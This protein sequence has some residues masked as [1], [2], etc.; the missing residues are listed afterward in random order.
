MSGAISLTDSN[1]AAAN[2]STPLS[3]TTDAG[4]HFSVTFTSATPGHVTGHASSTLDLGAVSGPFTVQRAVRA[5]TDPT[6]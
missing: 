5:S 2:P 3:G 6:R 4:G 1:G